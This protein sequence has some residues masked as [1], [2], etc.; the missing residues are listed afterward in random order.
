[1]IINLGDANSPILAE[2]TPEEYA[3]VSASPHYINVHSVEFPARFA[4][5]SPVLRAAKVKVSEGEGEG[6]GEGEVKVKVKVKV[7]RG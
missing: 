7:R 1:M 4:A 2:L 5:S 3:Q 6:E